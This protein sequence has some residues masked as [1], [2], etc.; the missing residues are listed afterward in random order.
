VLNSA[1]HSLD[2]ATGTT[3]ATGTDPA[4][5]TFDVLTVSFGAGAG[6]LSVRYFAALDAFVFHRKPLTAELP[7]VWPAF[8][9][10]DQPPNHTRCLGWDEHYFYPGGVVTDLAQCGSGGPLFLFEPPAQSPAHANE[11]PV[12]TMLLSPLSHFGTNRVVN[13]PHSKTPDP[14]TCTLGVDAAAGPAGLDS[15]LFQTAAVMFGRPGL[16]RATRAF[17]SIARQY[18]ATHRSRGP[19]VSQ[20]SYWNDNQA[21]QFA[22]VSPSTRFLARHQPLGEEDAVHVCRHCRLRG[23]GLGSGLG[24]AH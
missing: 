23:C 1:A 6:A 3:T 2:N 16:V 17:G 14:S 9:I 24:R 20:L 5:G 10:A 8:G 13:C 4:L 12:G 15:G 19:G 21:G 7:T 18:H 11:P 22:R